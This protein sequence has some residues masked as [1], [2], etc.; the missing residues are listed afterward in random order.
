MK[1]AVVVEKINLK[2]VFNNYKDARKELTAT[3]KNWEKQINELEYNNPKRELLC[4]LYFT[5]K[6]EKV[7]A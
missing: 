6:L 3:K 2:K 5:A 7:S 4:E 1:Y